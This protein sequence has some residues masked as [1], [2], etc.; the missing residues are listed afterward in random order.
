MAGSY[1]SMGGFEEEWIVAKGLRSKWPRGDA[2]RMKVL[3]GQHR[4]ARMSQRQQLVLT[5]CLS[6]SRS[7]INVRAVYR[8]IYFCGGSLR[9]R[10]VREG[11]FRLRSTDPSRQVAYPI[12]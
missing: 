9:R 5:V 8:S 4:P 2:S 1:G 3:G 12:G 10:G 11:G 6:H 7:P